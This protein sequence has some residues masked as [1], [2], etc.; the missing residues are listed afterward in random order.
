[1]R[2]VPRLARRLRLARASSSP[3]P[4]TVVGT[5]PK[6]ARRARDPGL[7]AQ[8]R[9]DR[10]QGDL[11]EGRLR[12]LPHA[13]RRRNATGTVGPNLDQAKPDYRLAT[14]RVT[15]GKGVDAVVQ[16]PAHRPADRR[17]RRLRR[18]VDRRHSVAPIELPAGFP[19]HVAAFAVDL[20]RTLIAKDAVLRPRT[21]EAIAR[22]RAAGHARD[23]RHRPDVPLGAAVPRR[24]GPRRSGRLL[25]GRRRR[26]PGDRRVPAPRADP[27]RGRARGDRRRRSRPASTSTATSTTSCTS[28]R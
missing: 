15:L 13:R 22:V 17:R 1:M 6:P 24:G 25:P 23:R 5:L 2:R 21:R 11:H 9:P 7:Q 3:A 27:A 18:Q 28:P 12:R 16:G 14:A 19:P 10:G 20:D 8:G 26:R 4:E